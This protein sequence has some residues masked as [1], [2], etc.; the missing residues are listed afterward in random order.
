MRRPLPSRHLPLRCPH[1]GEEEMLALRHRILAS[2]SQYTLRQLITSVIFCAAD[3]VLHR[4]GSDASDFLRGLCLHF[5][6][7]CASARQRTVKEEGQHIDEGVWVEALAEALVEEERERR[8]TA[9]SCIA[10]FLSALIQLVGAEAAGSRP[11]IA[12][13]LSQLCHCCHL[14]RWEAKHS[15]CSGLSILVQALSPAWIISSQHEIIKSLMATFVDDRSENTETTADKATHALHLIVNC[16]VQAARKEVEGEGAAAAPAGS[17]EP[18]VAGKDGAAAADG[19]ERKAVDGGT[20]I[21][22]EVVE[23][24]KQAKEKEA[25]EEVKEEE[26]RPEPQP[27]STEEKELEIHMQTDDDVSSKAAEAASAPADSVASPAPAAAAQ[28]VVT[29]A[30]SRPVLD[31]R[32]SPTLRHL[33]AVV[34]PCLISNVSAM[35]AAAQS[36]LSFIAAAMNRPLFDILQPHRDHLL[37]HVYTKGLHTVSIAVRIGHLSAATYLLTLQPQPLVAVKELSYL[38]KIVMEVVDEEQQLAGNF[39]SRTG[40]AQLWTRLR[41]ES[42]QLMSAALAHEDV[43]RDP[44]AHKDWREAVIR[45]F[46][47]S[48]LSRNPEINSAAKSGLRGVLER[49][50]IPKDLL[51]LCLRPI[52]LNLADHRKLSVALLEGLVRLLELLWNCFNVTLGEKLL[53]HLRN[54]ANV[55]G[56]SR[57]REEAQQDKSGTLLKLKPEEEVKIPLCI[58]EL[59]HLLPPAPEGKFLEALVAAVIK[60]E[61]VLPMIMCGGLATVPTHH[62]GYTGAIIGPSAPSASP[63]QPS[64]DVGS[65]SPYRLPLLKFLNK[66]PRK[67]LEY[68]LRNLHRRRWSSLLQSLLKYSEAEPLRDYL[69]QHQDWLDMWTFHFDRQ[70]AEQSLVQPQQQQ[71]Q[72][73]QEANAQP[74]QQAAG[75]PAGP[76]PANGTVGADGAAPA[77]PAAATNADIALANGNGTSG[78]NGLPPLENPAAFSSSAEAETA[79]AAPAAPGAATQPQ[80]AGDVTMTAADNSA[81]PSVPAPVAPV[82]P[83]QVAPTAA[84]AP[85]ASAPMTV[86]ALQELEE[87]TIAGVSLV[88]VLSHARAEFITPRILKCLY[89]VWD[90][91]LRIGRLLREETLPLHY[92]EETKNLVLCLVN[93][94][95]LHRDDVTCLTKLL[96]AFRIRS[97]VDFS[98]LVDFLDTELS[99]SYSVAEKR[100][101]LR[102]LLQ[103]VDSAN[104]SAGSKSRALKLIVRPMLKHALKQRP[105]RS[106]QEIRDE[107]LRLVE[108]RRSRGEAKDAADGAASREPKKP[109]DGLPVAKDGESASSGAAA[110]AGDSKME[111][112]EKGG[113]AADSADDGGSFGSGAG[114]NGNV[115]VLPPVWQEDDLLDTDMVD[116]LM[117]AIS[118]EHSAPGQE[119]V[120]EQTHAAAPLPLLSSLPS[121]DDHCPSIVNP[122][123]TLR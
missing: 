80:P 110:A 78:A 68:F 74:Q 46:F 120:T 79:A 62:T 40:R 75:A 12:E 34:A 94:A 5:A 43:R 121:S 3:P 13:L 8:E 38:V 104:T 22:M 63:A 31:E 7:V 84:A 24:E 57:M 72:Q 61:E 50:K 14:D 39:N 108:E 85:S 83:P 89:E 21:V 19:E 116:S 107:Q 123:D 1:L 100:H 105:K 56:L 99:A 98:F 114:D 42:L 27:S 18:A 49:E 9:L 37:Q 53:D 71:Q 11:V 32:K 122:S 86:Q 67:S 82:P 51:Q 103:Y 65:S 52:L 109:D 30:S 81:P 26:K 95:R 35:R 76:G 92:V 28:A 88:L 93:Y 41:V 54:F 4:A 17:K 64:R 97:L 113:A 16:T 59:F 111:L 115:P 25:K 96:A 60:L 69:M 102:H 47:R 73:Q 20:T 58:I 6:S 106:Q 44:R 91:K 112:D 10:V 119:E 15:G 36:L 2:A 23:E 77:P 33:I 118:L 66:S 29:V 45:V 90:G 70:T 55:E 117:H 87:R 101:V 48:L